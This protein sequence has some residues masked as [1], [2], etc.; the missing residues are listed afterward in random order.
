MNGL[1]HLWRERINWVQASELTIAA[2]TTRAAVLLPGTFHF[3]DK[4]SIFLVAV[5]R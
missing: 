2:A 1:E 3:R 5:N 4:N